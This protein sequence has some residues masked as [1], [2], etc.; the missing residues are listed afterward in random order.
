MPSGRRAAAFGEQA[1]FQFSFPAT[2]EVLGV[3]GWADG[4]C[5]NDAMILSCS[6]PSGLPTRWNM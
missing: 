2:A 3:K 4:G 1:M 6:T 5:N